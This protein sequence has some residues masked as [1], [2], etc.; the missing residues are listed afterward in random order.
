VSSDHLTDFTERQLTTRLVYDGRLLKVR[1]DTVQLPDGKTARREYVEHPGAVMIVAM[2]DEKTVLLERQFRYAPR[3]HFLEL[4]AG[5][6]EM[7]ETPLKTAQR[8][9]IEECGYQ[10][11]KWQHLTSLYSCIGYS[12]ELIEFYLAR[13]LTHVGSALDDGE[14]LEVVAVSLDEALKLVRSRDIT[15][16]KTVAGLAWVGMYDYQIQD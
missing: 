8:E 6:I 12:N 15:D 16:I 5:K 7:G 13:G 4:P 14:F 2:P 11:T 9:L 10:A 1:E 3:R